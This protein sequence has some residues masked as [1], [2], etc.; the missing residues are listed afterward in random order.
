MRA[1]PRVGHHCAAA[2][3]SLLWRAA[4]ALP[5]PVLVPGQLAWRIRTAV[6][7]DPADPE[8]DAFVEEI[9]R[10]PAR[11]QP[12]TRRNRVRDRRCAAAPARSST[13]W[14]R[15]RYWRRCLR[16]DQGGGQFARCASHPRESQYPV[17]S[18]SMCGPLSRRSHGAVGCRGRRERLRDLAAVSRS[19]CRG[20]V[21]RELR[22]PAS[23][24][25]CCW[26]AWTATGS[27]QGGG[28]HDAV[29]VTAASRTSGSSASVGRTVSTLGPSGTGPSDPASWVSAAQASPAANPAAIPAPR[30]R[31]NSGGVRSTGQ[32]MTS[33]TRRDGCSEPDDL[34]PLTIIQR[35]GPT[36]GV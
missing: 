30:A 34:G 36:R 8:I 35:S 32:L 6:D 9:T 19:S 12:G 21:R 14:L 25:A 20:T 18:N 26:S 15:W 5:D 2:C 27:A 10:T 13:G 33:Q 16:V 29:P 31:R 3:C 1:S 17:S 4:G 28:S 7:G 11:H 22:C 24:Q 23:I